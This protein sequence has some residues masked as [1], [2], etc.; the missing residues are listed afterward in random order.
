MRLAPTNYAYGIVIPTAY[1]DYNGHMA[2]PRAVDGDALAASD[3]WVQFSK[4]V[5]ELTGMPVA[6]FTPTGTR[7]ARHFTP[8]DENPICRE[9]Q[10]VPE[11]LAAC[12]ACN[13]AEFANVAKTRK[14]SRYRCH[15]G[16]VDIALPVMH[17]GSLIAVIST[18]QLLPEPACDTGFEA[19]LPTCE[20]FGIPPATMRE[21]YSR[22][23]YLSQAKVDSVTALLTF[24]AEHLC[25]MSRR[26]RDLTED[27]YPAIVRQAMVLIDDR[28]GEDLSLES[29]A[30]AVD[31]S[32]GYLGRRFKQALGVSFTDYVRDARIGQAKQHLATSHR[33]V[34][35]IA[36]A[37]GFGSLSQFN[38]TFL[39]AVGCTPR[40]Y[41]RAQTGH[42]LGA[43]G[44]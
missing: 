21:A 27:K 34:A 32:P 20:R 14:A 41:R 11:G 39:K 30:E 9:I 25:E 35:D 37:C 44:E 28:L 2:M 3:A 19:L 26:I 18:G 40:A 10:A 1:G 16:L 15:A 31:Y 22:A 6:L 38:R 4:I 24:F 17:D 7:S 29:V 8:E 13:R 12:M 36:F 42:G 33:A 23:P 5:L 43:N